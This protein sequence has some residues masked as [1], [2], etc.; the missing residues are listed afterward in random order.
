M[1]E[2]WQGDGPSYVAPT[3]VLH[4]VKQAW[5]A[6]RLVSGDVFKVENVL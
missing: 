4:S 1:S 5:P 3:G 6:F 2:L